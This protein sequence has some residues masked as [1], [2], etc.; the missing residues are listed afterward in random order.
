M[1]LSYSRLKPGTF[2]GQD[3][4]LQD[5][6][7]VRSRDRQILIG[8]L[9]H[10][11]LE[12]WDFQDDPEKLPAWSESVCRRGIPDEWVEDAQGLVNELYDMFN[13]FVCTTPYAILSQAE[14]LGREVPIT[15][16][17]QAR[18]L[19]GAIDKNDTPAVL[20]GVIDVVYRWKHQIWMADYKTALVNPEILEQVVASYR[21]Q[22]TAYRE[23]LQGVFVDASVKAQ[24]IFVRN[25]SSVEV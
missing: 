5:G 23:A 4:S 9:V 8:I 12:T 19:S 7:P 24:L 15:V 17:W 18:H 13:A 14:I 25:G 2:E 22:A 1:P 11:V 10:R 6:V 21:V 20:H 16:P 3:A